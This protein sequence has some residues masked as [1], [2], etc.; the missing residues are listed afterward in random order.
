M[1]GNKAYWWFSDKAIREH[2]QHTLMLSP[3]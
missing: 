2:S 1:N 3:N